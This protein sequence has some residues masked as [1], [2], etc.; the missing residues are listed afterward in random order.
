M[1]K[2][3]ITMAHLGEYVISLNQEA[4]NILGMLSCFGPDDRKDK[5]IVKKSFDAMDYLF[6]EKYSSDKIVSLFKLCNNDK[7][8]FINTIVNKFADKE[9]SNTSKT[10]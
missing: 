8:T 1:K 7:H 6:L 2:E 5:D 3:D 10:K 4:R 9:I